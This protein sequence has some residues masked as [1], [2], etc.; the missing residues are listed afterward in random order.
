MREDAQKAHVLA[1]RGTF[2]RNVATYTKRGYKQATYKCVTLGRARDLS[3]QGTW[4]D[5]PLLI[6]LANTQEPLFIINRSG[7]RPSDEGAA[8]WL[9]RA[10]DLCREAG[11]RRVRLRGD[12]AF[13]Q[14][15]P[16]DR[17][18]DAGRVFQFGDDA[19]PKLKKLADELPPQSWQTLRRIPG[20]VPVG[21]TRAKPPKVKRQIIRRREFLHL[22]RNSEEVAEFD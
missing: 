10:A 5:H 15:T 16:R 8:G 22:E 18:D 3:D 11:F 13:S 7:N 4:G 1:K 21:K 19:R 9:D 12:T 6:S 17:W 2:W 20:H 14:T